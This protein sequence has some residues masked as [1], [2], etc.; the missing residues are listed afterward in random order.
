MTSLRNPSRFT[1]HVSRITFHVSRATFHVVTCHAKPRE[2]QK[3][4]KAV[5][6]L[7]FDRLLEVSAMKI[8]KTPITI[9][10]LLLLLSGMATL[11][12]CN[13]GATNPTAADRVRN[14]IND[15]NLAATAEADQYWRDA[16]ATTQAQQATQDANYRNVVAAATAEA[17]AASDLATRN[18]LEISLTVAAATRE[19]EAIATA[20]AQA[21]AIAAATEVAIV[22]QVTRQ[23]AAAQA[24]AARV[25]TRDAEI[26]ADRQRQIRR[27]DINYTIQT[28]L[29]LFGSLLLGFLLLYLLW[30][31]LPTLVN[32]ASLVRYG[33]H[34][35]PLLLTQRN[36]QMVV[37]DPLRM[38]QAAV[39]IDDNG[40]INMPSLTDDAIQTLLANGVLRTLIEQARH[41]PGHA[42]VLPSEV[43]RL[44][45]LGPWTSQDTTRHQSGHESGDMQSNLF[46][47]TGRAGSEAAHDDLAGLD[48]ELPLPRYVPWSLL[49]SYGGEGIAL[50][51]GRGQQIISLNLTHLPHLF[52]AGKSGSGKT[53]RLLRPLIAQALAD[54]YYTVLMNESGSDFSPFYD[55]D[56]VSIVR[57][58]VYTYMGII[59][60]AMSEMEDREQVLRD[61]RISE[62]GRLPTSLT[63]HRPFVLLAIDE[64]LA[65]ASILTPKEQKQFWALLTAFASRARKVGMCSLGLA[66]DP[67]YRALG[68]GGL[69]YRSQCGRIG[70]R[71]FQA[72]GSRA[73][74][75]EGGA[76]QLGEGQ[77]MALLS[78]PGLQTGVAANP[79]DG[80]L[81]T[82]LQRRGQAASQPTPSWLPSLA[83]GSHAPSNG[84]TPT[85]PPQIGSDYA[86]TLPATA[87]PNAT[88]SLT[89][90]K[91]ALDPFAQQPDDYRTLNAILTVIDEDEETFVGWNRNGEG[92]ARLRAALRARAEADGCEW[93]KSIRGYPWPHK[94]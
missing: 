10:L 5:L 2:I 34:G 91:Q 55:H 61:M 76:E 21:A 59:E 54:D 83:A 31:L 12:A 84:P 86:S 92:F 87:P 16:R 74:L 33:Q 78:D 53:R 39:T 3:T 73:I 71:M 46:A 68:Q 81:I 28:L 63:R 30:L 8:H 6:P 51:A 24:E 80:E 4:L 17:Q 94:K 69:N 77:F 19:A 7:A 26:A 65:L 52:V 57:G 15:P 41:A 47:L 11:A 89:L 56:N 38:H 18:A 50:G 36:G 29:T 22:A 48:E 72:A 88:D 37:T 14:G 49:A 43:S 32:R 67:T 82:Y 60:A 58:D 90:D 42:P 20:E 79:S 40:Q 45:R 35:N 64:L 44:R 62:W 25:A 27:D 70:F 23:A 1:Y 75:D 13:N 9:F 85:A 66:T 93:A